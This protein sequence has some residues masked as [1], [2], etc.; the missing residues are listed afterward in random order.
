MSRACRFATG[1]TGR[2]YVH[3]DH[4][5]IIFRKSDMDAAAVHTSDSAA[6]EMRSFVHMPENP[7]YSP[8]K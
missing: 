7:R 2:V 5:M 1:R 3:T 6:L 8:R 4:R